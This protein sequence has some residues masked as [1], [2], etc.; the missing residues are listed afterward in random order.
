MK[1]SCICVDETQDLLVRQIQLFA[2]ACA[3]E[4]AYSFAADTAQ[5]IEWGRTFNFAGLRDAI[6]NSAATV[7]GHI[8]AAHQ[9]DVD[10]KVIKLTKNFRSNQ[11]LLN[12]HSTFVSLIVR[13]FKEDTD[14]MEGE[15]SDIKDGAK[16]VLVVGIDEKTFA[17]GF[18]K[19]RERAADGRLILTD[20]EVILVNEGDEESTRA[21]EAHFCRGPWSK[22]ALC[23]SQQKAKGLEFEKVV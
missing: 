19:D 15:T 7:T 4:E 1:A 14:K 11:K 2:A 5:T 10:N 16:P 21:A 9:A 6:L 12:F 8:T 13:F 18:A 20:D 23:L 22:I 17:G 3:E